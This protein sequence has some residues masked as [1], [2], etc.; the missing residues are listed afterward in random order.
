MTTS[1]FYDEPHYDNEEWAKIINLKTHQ[2]N[3][4]EQAFLKLIDYEAFVSVDNFYTKADYILNFACINSLF[5]S[6]I[7]EE[8]REAIY[9]EILMEI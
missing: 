5:E 6:E 8:I 4:Y 2:V 3:L 7:I 9:N 1:K